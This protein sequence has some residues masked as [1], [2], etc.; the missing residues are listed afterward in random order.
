MFNYLFAH[1]DGAIETSNR[2]QISSFF[3]IID[4]LKSSNHGNT[5]NASIP[6]SNGTV[7][8]FEVARTPKSLPTHLHST[9][10][11]AK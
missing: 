9:L 11:K 3:I 8:S 5:F 2:V 7:E 6:L 1:G 10:E 4:S